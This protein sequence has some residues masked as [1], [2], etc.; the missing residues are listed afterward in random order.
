MTRVLIAEDNPVNSALLVDLLELHGHEVVQAKNGK[1]AVVAARER[2]PDII[3]LDMM[4]PVMDGFEVAR[5]L[6][7]DGPTKS[8]PII[9]LTAL[10]MTGDEKRALEAGC[11]AY[12]SKPIDTRALP[13]LLDKLLE[14]GGPP[15]VSERVLAL[16]ESQVREASAAVMGALEVLERR[17]NDH[18]ALETVAFWAHRLR[19]SSGVL[20]LAALTE[21]L[22]VLET[23]ARRADERGRLD[24]AGLHEVRSALAE[25]RR[26]REDVFDGGASG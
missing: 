26:V 3:L 25:L 2:H 1:E 12:V 5:I 22:H 15:P 19:G 8:I 24:E 6:K 11:D 18:A 23:T 13:E 10:A 21:K 20:G 7:G 17:P 4:M 14:K 16:F 9:A